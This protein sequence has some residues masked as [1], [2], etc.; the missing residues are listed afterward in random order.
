M[1]NDLLVLTQQTNTS[2]IKLL[3]TKKRLQHMVFETQNKKLQEYSK[4]KVT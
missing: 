3:N 2:L 1:G 4:Q